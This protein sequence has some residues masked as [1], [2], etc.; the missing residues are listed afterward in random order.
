VD[1]IGEFDGTIPDWYSHA[2]F[3]RLA[4]MYLAVAATGAS[5]GKPT[6]SITTITLRAVGG[7]KKP[8]LTDHCPGLDERLWALEMAF[9]GV[10]SDIQWKKR[11]AK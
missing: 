7:P 4:E 11:A 10:G 6:E 3:P 2:S 8:E 9:R 5:T 1:R